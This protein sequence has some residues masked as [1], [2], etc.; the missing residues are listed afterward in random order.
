MRFQACTIIARNY[1][2]QA[3]VFYR[4]LRQFHPDIRFSALVF[5]AERGEVDEPFDHLVLGDIG[6]PAGEETRMPMLYDVTELA[7]ALKPWFFRHLLGREQTALLYFDPDIEIFSPLDRLAQLADEHC[8]VVTPHTTQPMRRADVRPNETDILSAGAYN[9]GFLGLNADCARFLDWWSERLLREAII[10]VANMRFT[11]QR[12]MDFAPGYFDTCILKDETC[13]VAYWNADSRPL[14]WTGTRYEVKGEPLCFF[15]FSGFRPERPHLLS[16]HQ[17]TNPRTRL[18]QDPALARLCQ[19]YANKLDDSDYARLHR[20]PYGLEKASGG[21]KITRPMRLAYRVAL[22]KHEE[23]GTEAPPSPFSDR[24]GFVAWLNEP[25]HPRRSPEITRYFWAIHAARPDLRAMF[26]NLMGMDN[27][28]YYQWLRQ[29][30][31]QE[32]PIPDELMPRPPD[33]PSMA[34][35][36]GGATS[37]IPGVALSGHLRAEVGTGEASRL[38]AAA[39]RA[40]GEKYSAQV[41]SEARSRQHH[42]WND[43]SDF[44]A[45][46]YDTNL[47]CINADL[48]PVFA[49]EMGPEFFKDR[50]N[51]GLWFWETEVFPP[52][53]HRG[54]K[55]LHEVWVTGEFVHEAIARVSPI[56]VFTIPLPL[57]IDAPVPPQVSRSALQLPEGFLFLFSF[58]FF[59]VFERKNPIG[60]IEAFKRAFA[61]GEGPILLI[62]SINGDRNLADLERLYHARGERSDIIIRDG[63]LTSTERD[64]LNSACDCYV[65]LHRS[66]GFGLTIAEA[67]LLEKPAI[68]TRYSGNLEFM[69]DSNSFLCGYELKRVGLG[70][71]P[72]PPEA[73][74]A[75]PNI[76]EAAG[77]MRFVYENPKEAQRRGK[78]GRLDLYAGHD[79]KIAGAFIKSR[80][81]ELRRNPPES[82][83][84]TAQ[85]PERPLVTKVRVAIEQGVNVRRIVPSLL[86]WIL[87]GP[88][89]AMKKFLRAY[90]QHH[91]RLGLF[92]LDAF[93]EIDAEWLRERASLIKRMCTQ[94]D[95]VNLLKKELKET[96]QLLSDTAKEAR[97]GH[98]ALP[99]EE[100]GAADEGR[101]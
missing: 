10:D 98:A 21:L 60:V 47:V 29:D 74:W 94:E 36:D 92:V 75:N 42:P 59:S 90:D 56:P 15:H 70:S 9:L 28:A 14:T 88:R 65:S 78:K 61:P 13:N 57:N 30:G 54:F 37:R 22:R 99:L 39:L 24:A 4:S 23:N 52:A 93:K 27:G 91:R 19:E 26:P 46:S 32:V 34:M 101:M 87:Q 2:P 85:N 84:F 48:L 69:T 33:H 25:L 76:D 83:P 79:P 1:L 11:D 58:D 44:S 72:Y 77:L 51:I 43:D 55:F 80:L 95:E 53:M 35:E 96:R 45:S 97:D 50:Y 17:S 5:D 16:S 40:S 18:S 68:A 8:L 66:E 82:L 38:M 49:Q 31:R 71:S 62:K 100:T 64:A 41:Y 86:T 20:L 7:T 89:R 81:S 3:R 12:W 6:L 73:R 63:Y 67:M